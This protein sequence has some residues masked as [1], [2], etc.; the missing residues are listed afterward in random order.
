M[1]EFLVMNNEAIHLFLKRGSYDMAIKLLRTTMQRLRE[2]MDDSDNMEAFDIDFCPVQMNTQDASIFR[3]ASPSNMFTIYSNAFTTQ[4][5]GSVDGKP[6]V[7]LI[8]VLIFN[9]ALVYHIRGLR[10]PTAPQTDLR[11]ALHYY[12]LGLTIVQQHTRLCADS[13]I[14][15]LISLA[16]LNNAGHVFFHFFKMEEAKQCRDH[17]DCL[18]Q[19]DH[20]F[21]ISEEHTEVF[22]SN[23]FFSKSCNIRVAAA[24]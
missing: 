5:C 6:P 8:L 12:K 14:F 11:A 16:L 13:S 9:L 10:H 24:A 19:G 23:V 7:E 1:R 18:L 22:F 21:D 15:Y 3:D 17:M 2:V 4:T 20:L